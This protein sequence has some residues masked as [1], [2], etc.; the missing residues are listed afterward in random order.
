MK[1]LRIALALI[2]LAA[3]LPACQQTGGGG[4][5][6]GGGGLS[7][8]T[9]ATSQVVVAFLPATS[10]DFERLWAGTAGTPEGAVSCFVI[11]AMM[12]EKDPVLGEQCMT[13]IASPEGYNI[14]DGKPGFSF[15]ELV[16][17]FREQPWL[18]RSYVQGA[19]PANGYS[20]PTPYRIVFDERA[21]S[22]LG[23]PGGNKTKVFVV[24]GGADSPRPVT[25]S[26]EA[27]GYRI[28]EAS[29]LSVGIRPPQR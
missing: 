25:V 13:R 19:T 28:W 27:A 5:T 4:T 29:S 17:R 16:R 8:F 14:T 10:Q 9:P 20:A 18:A 22:P 11:A 24:C 7:P 1:T 12:L 26:R 15:T 2:A 6:T 23:Q 3:L 21:G